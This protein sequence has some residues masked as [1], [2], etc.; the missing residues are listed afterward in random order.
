MS[1]THDSPT[2][3]SPP[4]RGRVQYHE[5]GISNACILIDADGLRGGDPGARPPSHHVHC[6]YNASSA[7][8]RMLELLGPERA[9]QWMLGRY[10]IVNAWRPLVQPVERSPLG[11][12]LPSSVASGDWVDVDIVFPDRRG[13]IR[14]LAWNPEHR[15]IYRDRMHPRETALFTV[16][17]SSGVT[18]V[19]H[20]A[21]ELLEAPEDAPPRQS[22]ES[23]MFVRFD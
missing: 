17:A 19:A 21:V 8:K 2:L 1:S 13:Q 23:R 12:V 7:H 18:G 3:G 4:T 14:G 16:Y 20:A 22:I 11:F 9:R 10:A 6:D 15:W 5:P